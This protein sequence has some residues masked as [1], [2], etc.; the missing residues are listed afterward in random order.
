MDC[1]TTSMGIRPHVQML[2]RKIRVPEDVDW[3]DFYTVTIKE[4][5]FSKYRDLLPRLLLKHWPKVA[6]SMK[7]RLRTTDVR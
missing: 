7:R 5:A 3:L 2:I 4:I 1:P 6:E